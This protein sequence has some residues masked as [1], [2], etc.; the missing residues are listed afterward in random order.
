LYA[1]KPDGTPKVGI[2]G[3]SDGKNGILGSSHVSKG[4][5]KTDGFEPH[6]PT[7]PV[8]AYSIGKSVNPIGVGYISPPGYSTPTI[9]SAPSVET[10]A[11][12]ALDRTESPVAQSQIISADSLYQY[13][14]SLSSKVTILF[15][16]LRNRETYDAGHIAGDSCCV[17]QFGLSEG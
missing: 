13:M 1:L 10:L 17:E 9:P 16:D 15:L 6:L 11:D 12:G 5:G 3:V 4:F 7:P 2:N 14:T 8:P